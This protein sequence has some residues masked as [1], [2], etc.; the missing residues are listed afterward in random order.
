MFSNNDANIS[1]HKTSTHN[2]V[3]DYIISFNETQ[4]DID[5]VI[6]CTQNMFRQLVAHFGDRYLLKGRLVA[7]AVYEHDQR[8]DERSYHFPSYRV[9]LIDD[10]DK[11]YERH[12]DKIAS[13]MEDFHVNGSNLTFKRIEHIHICLY[14]I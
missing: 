4:C 14:K 1:L 5:C 3:E 2:V 8:R 9:E 10:P 7:K 12:I 6:K 13:R 11:F